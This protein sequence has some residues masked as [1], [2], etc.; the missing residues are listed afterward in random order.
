M[1]VFRTLDTLIDHWCERRA[2]RPLQH[3]LRAYPAVFVHADQK[4]ALL[5][6]LKDVRDF[7][8]R[9]LTAEECVWVAKL[10]RVVE[11]SLGGVL[12]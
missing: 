3:L 10:C 7:C 6:A 8:R 12:R 9:D 1:D 2:I 5:D 4:F 11:D